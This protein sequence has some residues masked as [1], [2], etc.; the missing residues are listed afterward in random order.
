M[1]ERHAQ[2]QTNKNDISYLTM[3]KE[4]SRLQRK[5]TEWKRQSRS[6]E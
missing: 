5:V 4:I 2:T 3:L 6:Q 1:H